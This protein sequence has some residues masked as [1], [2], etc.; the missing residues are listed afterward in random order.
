[1]TTISADEKSCIG[2]DA[3]KGRRSGRDYSSSDESCQ[4]MPATLPTLNFELYFPRCGAEY[5]ARAR[6]YENDEKS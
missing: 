3:T 6:V 4:G 1:M 5:K 2:F